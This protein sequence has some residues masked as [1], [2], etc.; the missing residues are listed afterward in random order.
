MALEYSE[1][2]MR[3]TTRIAAVFLCPLA[4]AL[5]VGAQTDSLQCSFES[6]LS[7]TNVSIRTHDIAIAGKYAYVG[8]LASTNDFGIEIYDI[9]DPSQPIHSGSAIGDRVEYIVISDTTAFAIAESPTTIHALDISNPQ[10]PSTIGSLPIPGSL[11][12]AVLNGSSLYVATYSHSSLERGIY[13]IDVSDPSAMIQTDRLTFDGY[14]DKMAF[15]ND[16]LFHYAYPTGLSVYDCTV[17]TAPKLLTVYEESRFGNLFAAGENLLY[18]NHDDD[19]VCAIDVSNPEAI[20]V[21]GEVDMPTLLD[22]VRD[23]NIGYGGGYDGLYMFDL[24]DP[25]NPTNLGS[26]DSPTEAHSVSVHN[27]LVFLAGPGNGL[28]ILEINHTRASP[29][30]SQI[31]PRPGR[32][33]N[34]S[35]R[36]IARHGDTVYLWHTGSRSLGDELLR[37][38]VSDPASPVVLGAVALRATDIQFSDQH[39]HIVVPTHSEGYTIFEVQDPNTWNPVGSLNLPGWDL[40]LRDQMAFMAGDNNSTLVVVDISDPTNPT[41]IGSLQHAI[42]GYSIELSGNAAFLIDY[43]EPTLLTVDV[44]VPTTPSATSTT[45][46]PGEVFDIELVDNW[47]Y[48]IGRNDIY[49]LDVSNPATPILTSTTPLIASSVYVSIHHEDGILFAGGEQLV[50]LDI[51]NPAQPVVNGW[52]DPSNVLDAG[53]NWMDIASSNGFA[54]INAGE[55]GLQIVDVSGPCDTPCLADTNHDG[56]LSPTDFTAWVGAFNNQLPE[57]DQ[58]NDG[59]CTPT[60]FTAWVGNYNAGCD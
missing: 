29:L 38:D 42:S 27:G 34:F 30:L 16:T 10:S 40:E 50:T 15:L 59:S 6:L 52:Y 35:E 54:Y 3:L 37:I 44:S 55:G 21:L 32:I 46:L 24:T 23:G 33:S 13:V 28:D 51:S 41:Q 20:Q 11:D 26:I 43:G 39:V 17:P 2:F 31:P 4:A 5:S 9:S 18:A 7:T 60:D 1:K 58:N 22:Y 45:Q 36:A 53:T 49:T 47:L 48:A 19:R 56:V 8:T 12:S 14:S 25:T 57:C